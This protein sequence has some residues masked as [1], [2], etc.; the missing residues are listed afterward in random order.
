MAIINS[1]L[2]LCNNMK[3]VE[4]MAIVA[5]RLILQS[6]N[7]SKLCNVLKTS[8]KVVSL[9]AIDSYKYQQMLTECD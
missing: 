6:K 2:V 1:C 8:I 4:F 9:D 5:V 7:Y 3:P